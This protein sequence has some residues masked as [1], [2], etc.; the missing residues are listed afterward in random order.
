MYSRCGSIS[1]LLGLLLIVAAFTFLSE[2]AKAQPY[3]NEWINYDQR[4][5]R[6]PVSSEGIY[7]IN[8]NTLAAAGVPVSSIDPR[9]FQIFNR[10]QEVPIYVEGEGDG[11]FN[12]SDFIEFYATGNDGWM[13]GL[14]YDNPANQTNVHYSL[15]NDTIHYYLTWNSS[16]ENLRFQQETNQN[17]DGLT[18]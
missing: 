8:Y 11:I 4:Y 2:A 17:L 16:I 15:F 13:D 3:G 7:K 10:Q 9:N 14:V 6:F 12:L 18:H 1:K 5:Y